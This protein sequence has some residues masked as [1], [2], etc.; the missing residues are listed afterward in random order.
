MN[1]FYVL[2]DH[3]Q[4]MIIT[5]IQ[6]LPENWNNINGLNL[7]DSEKLFNLDWVGQIGLGWVKI[8]DEIL[9]EYTVLPGGLKLV[10][11]DLKH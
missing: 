6:K 5:P 1:D 10:N 3:I 9:D 2:V 11:L 8:S 7:F 4:K